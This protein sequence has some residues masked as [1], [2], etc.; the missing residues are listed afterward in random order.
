MGQPG[1]LQGGHMVRVYPIVDVVLIA[2]CTC[3][4]GEGVCMS[5]CVCVCDSDGDSN[6]SQEF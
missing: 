6:V 5:V 1:V 4:G 3:V 2:L